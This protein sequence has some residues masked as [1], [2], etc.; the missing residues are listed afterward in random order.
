MARPQCDTPLVLTKDPE[1]FWFAK[2]QVTQ[3]CSLSP[4]SYELGVYQINSFLYG[5]LQKTR[6]CEWI[7]VKRE[8][9][10]LKMDL[11]FEKLTKNSQ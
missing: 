5:P 11:L 2:C 3:L 7:W 1:N 9:E 6:S 10:L 8:D 4:A